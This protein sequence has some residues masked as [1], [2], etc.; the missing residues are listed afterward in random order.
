METLI[1]TSLIIV[2]WVG[3][4][5]GINLLIGLLNYESPFDPEFDNW[6]DNE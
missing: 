6:E 5:I 3:A 4:A 1:I 2:G